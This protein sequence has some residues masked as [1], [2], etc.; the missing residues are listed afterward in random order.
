MPH[1]AQKFKTY[2]EFALATV[3]EIYTESKLNESLRLACH[4][5]NSGVFLNDGALGFRFLPLPRIAQ[6]APVFGA[7]A[8]DFDGDGKADLYLAQNFYGPQ[9]ETGHMDGGVSQFLRG[10]GDGSF[11]AIEPRDSGL[12][13]SGDAKGLAVTD[14]DADGNP[15]FL[16]ALNSGPVRSFVRKGGEPLRGVVLK[17]PAGNPNAIGSRVAAEFTDGSTWTGEVY[18]GSGYLSQSTPK[19]TIPDRPVRSVEVRWPSSETR[20]YT[21]DLDKKPLTIAY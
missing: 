18:A 8:G 6:I 12:L 2:H 17:G 4:E 5:L 13:V 11:E 14:I 15:D 19:L 1:L 16:V 21:E 20:K 3:T 9:V 7:A 10:R